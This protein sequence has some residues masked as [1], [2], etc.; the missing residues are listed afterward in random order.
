MKRTRSIKATFIAG[1]LF[2]PSA[3]LGAQTAT[4]APAGVKDA[5]RVFAPF[6]SRITVMEKEGKVSLSWTD[7]R[8]ATGSVVIFRSEQP[9]T[10]E[11]IARAERLAEVPYGAQS[12]IDKPPKGGLWHYFVAASD[13][14]GSRYDVM[15]P[16]VNS[17][18]ARIAVT[19]AA[20]AAQTP[21][22]ATG[23]AASSPAIEQPQPTEAA[24]SNEKKISGVS[25]QVQG[26]SVRISFRSSSTVSN[27]LVY[28]SASPLA[29][30]RD[31]LDAV[32]VQSAPASVAPVIDY[33]VPGIG[34]FYAL[35]SEDDLKAGRIAIE[36]GIN[37]TSVPV[38]VPAGRY[39]V[40]L[41]GPPSDIRSM[42]L[43]IISLDAAMPSGTFGPLP[44]ANPTQLS[45]AAAKAV[46]EL[47]GS[48]RPIKLTE[49][50]PRAFPQDLETPSGG[51]EYALRS[52]VQG[53]F[54]KKDWAESAKQI[55][56]YLSLSRTPASEARAHYYLGQSYFFSNRY[57]EALFEFLLAQSQYYAEGQ[58]WIDAILPRLSAASAKSTEQKAIRK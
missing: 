56:R 44:P 4:T 19:Q 21:K 1:L 36:R 3:F 38:E 14:K 28:R 17:L 9:I 50:R 55:V 15:L 45:S 24:K 47:I 11:K 13:T 12:F 49:R 16:Y 31:L 23:K 35:I 25:A 52:I 32:I 40:G 42:P 10:A 22:S 51:E 37:A 34:Y 53:T 39:R 57:S 20:P 6:V 8:D 5:E 26:D 58:E 30:T 7:S 2:L 29:E 46:A 41:P 54:A 18:D 48:V 33:P 43:P 27:I